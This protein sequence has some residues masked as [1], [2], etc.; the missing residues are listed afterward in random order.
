M[1]MA[2]VFRFNNKEMMNSLTALH[3]T[4]RNVRVAIGFLQTEGFG[5]EA[6]IDFRLTAVGGDPERS[7]K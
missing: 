3:R 2:I 6:K 1:R 7:F 5:A 4:S